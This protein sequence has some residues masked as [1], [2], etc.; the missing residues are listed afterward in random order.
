[1]QLS[2][3]LE[4]CQLVRYDIIFGTLFNLYNFHN[5]NVP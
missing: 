3:V 2:N 1:M 4:M 5:L